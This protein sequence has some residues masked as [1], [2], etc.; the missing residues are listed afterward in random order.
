MISDDEYLERLV[1][2]IQTAT[3]EGADVNW[4]EKINGRQFDVV[5]RFKVG[6]L[7]YLVLIEVK[8][9]KRRASAADIEA[10][11][12]KARDHRANKAVFVT[13]AGFQSGAKDV[14]QNHG[15][16]LFTVSF[17]S[18]A[19]SISPDA[20]VLIRRNP[21]APP[22]MEVD[23]SI[24]EPEITARII[25]TEIVY[26]DG[27]R[28]NVPSEPSQMVY[29]M[30]RTKLSDGRSLFQ[31]IESQPV[32]KIS[33]GER[34]FKEERFKRSVEIIPPDLYFFKRGR[35][36]A[37]NWNILG[38]VSRPMRGNIQIDPGMFSSQVLYTNEITGEVLT[39]RADQLPLGNQCVEP[40]KFYFIFNPL[41]YYQCDAIV[42]STVHWTAVETFQAGDFCQWRHTQ[43]V[44]WARSYIPVTDNTIIARLK[45]R[46][47][48]YES[49]VS[50][51]RALGIIP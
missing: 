38:H 29:Y 8:N 45:G 46:R 2:S 19:L 23:F 12:T 1:A 26:A 20:A 43:D 22:N 24:G 41:I 35:V 49:K 6:A 4:N 21:D 48:D 39:F 3:T 36:R 15:I 9:R 27:S 33:E 14:A 37:L 47:K 50:R 31:V 34:I 28:A 7:R 51:D 40:G 18:D 30:N 32:S 10:F 42:G 25:K 5:V 13:A 44:A 17:D 16:D 11:V